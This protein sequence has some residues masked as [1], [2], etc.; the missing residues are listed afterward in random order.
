MKNDITYDEALKL[1]K[2]IFIDVRSPKEYK[3]ATIPGAVNIPVLLDEERIRVGTLYAHDHISAAK[4]AGVEAISGRLPTIFREITQLYETHCIVVFCSR[5]G[6]RSTALSS[7]LYALDIKVHQLH[8]G[9]KAYR[10]WLLDHLP[11]AIAGIVPVTL[12]GNT[13]AGKTLLLHHLA[14]AGYP[15]IDLEALANHRGSLLGAVAHKEQPGQKS[16]D[17][18]LYALLEKYQGKTVFFEGESRRIGRIML[19]DELYNAICSRCM[20]WIDTPIEDR[21]KLLVAEYSPADEDELMG[22]LAKL[23]RYVGK[24]RIEELK[25]LLT[26]RKY[27]DAARE[28][29]EHYYDCNYK[30]P[31]T[32]WMK[33]YTN[34]NPAETAKTLAND[35][36][37]GLFR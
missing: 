7:F 4:Q 28:L 29:C 10:H 24:K 30:K 14:A 37:R 16:F 12:Y 18:A 20:V 15:V 11:H 6:Y 13:G 26:Q 9:Y 17:S 36:D 19:C 33:I 1:K 23:V 25:T 5:G 35:Y 2:P 22:A 8:G 34:D 31:T 32:N 21:V 27:H 3:E